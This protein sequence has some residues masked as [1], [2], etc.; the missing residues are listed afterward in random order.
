MP[1]NNSAPEQLSRLQAISMIKTQ[2]R[3]KYNRHWKNPWLPLWPFS[4]SS[5]TRA[6]QNQTT[7]T[8]GRD[9]IHKRHFFAFS[10]AELSD[11]AT[12]QYGYWYLYNFKMTEMLIKRR[13]LKATRHCFTFRKSLKYKTGESTSLWTFFQSPTCRYVACEIA[14][15]SI[16]KYY[17]SIEVSLSSGLAAEGQHD[18]TGNPKQH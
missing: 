15:Y 10:I 17:G 18:T 14:Q 5:H 13:L 7:L 8:D 11:S 2:L 9:K 12:R 6:Q 3:G 16:Q 1:L 4:A